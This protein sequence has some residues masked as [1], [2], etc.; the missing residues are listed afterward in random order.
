ARAGPARVAQ[1]QLAYDELDGPAPPNEAGPDEARGVG[2][3]RLLLGEGGQR[4]VAVGAQQEVAT[5]AVDVV[6]RP[7]EM[8]VRRQLH[9]DLPECV[10]RGHAP[11]DR[12]ECSRVETVECVENVLEPQRIGVPTTDPRRV[13]PTD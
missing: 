12:T 11:L 9:G 3:G 4:V 10:Q 5:V 7:L 8:A 13:R 6:I 1:A 2:S